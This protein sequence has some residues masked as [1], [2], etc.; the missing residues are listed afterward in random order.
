ML[1]RLHEKDEVWFA[2]TWIIIYVVGAS[3]FDRISNSMDFE[4]LFT[5]PFTLVLALCMFLCVKKNDWMEYYGLCRGKAPA[6]IFLFYIPMF[7]I[8]SVNL[9]FGV[10]INSDLA[11]SIVY[12]AYMLIVGFV[13]ELIFRGF[14]FKAMARTNL[15]A[16]IIVSSVTFGLGHFANFFNGNADLF[17]TAL[18]MIY[19]MALGFLFVVIMWKGKTMIP[20]IIAHS[21]NNVLSNFSNEEV[22]TREIRIG[23]TVV[24]CILSFI[25]VFYIIQSAD[26]CEGKKQ[27]QK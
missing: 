13:E 26:R 2:L 5:L 1:K 9:W 18:Q 25:Y 14:L 10:G 22:I 15:K 19:A 24:L 3:I 21:V 11:H 4:K 23:T 20:C 6:K 7:I 17:P 12:I 8:F 16:A 27:K